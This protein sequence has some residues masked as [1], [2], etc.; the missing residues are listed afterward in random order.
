MERD[1]QRDA[2]LAASSARAEELAANVRALYDR[3]APQF[4]DMD[5][6]D[7]MLILEMSLRPFGSGHRF[8]LVEV[9]PGVYV[10]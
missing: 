9:S 6:G 5:P 8:L 2:E 3:L 4:P 1:P 10:P 7:L